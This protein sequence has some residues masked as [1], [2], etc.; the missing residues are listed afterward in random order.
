MI[1]DSFVTHFKQLKSHPNAHIEFNI[2]IDYNQYLH[3]L[4]LLCS[5]QGVYVSNDILI[6]P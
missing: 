1:A 3:V 2:I 4:F 6:H 5:R